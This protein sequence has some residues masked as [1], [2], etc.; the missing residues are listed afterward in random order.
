MIFQK[1]SRK[2]LFMQ[3][4]KKLEDFQSTRQPL[5]LTIGNFDGMHRGHQAVLQKVQALAGSD[6]QTIVITFANHPSTVLRPEMPTSLLCHLPHKLHLIEE[7]KIDILMLLTFTSYLARHSAASFVERI[8]HFIPFTDLVLGYDATLGR[9]RQGNR[10]MMQ[11]L[12]QNW[13]F[14]IYYL[15]EYRFEGQ[16]VSS[17]R[18]REAVHQKD[19]ELVESL[20]DRPYSIYGSVISGQGEGK[21]IGY[22]TANLDVTGL[23]LPPF[24][25]YAVDMLRQGKRY[26]AIANLG[27]APTFG[28][29]TSPV[30][31]I[32]VFD[33]GEKIYEEV[34]E[35][36]FKQFIRFEQS[37]E[38][39]EHLKQQI[40]QDVL[41]AKACV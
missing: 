28:Q 30:L 10:G 31:E 19:F 23:C 37:F 17:T 26:P 14:N 1:R 41:K 5:V 8:R 32:H 3:V 25:V 40:A 16:A 2:G 18:I 7:F 9:D 20:L 35:V 29:K 39:V 33:F 24:G 11:E 22:A 21:Q 36:V 38:S 13:G 12:A 27:V 15:D 6:G 34:I 4:L